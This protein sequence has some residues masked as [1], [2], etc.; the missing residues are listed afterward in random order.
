MNLSGGLIGRAVVLVLAI[1]I[2]G[3]GDSDDDSGPTTGTVT[4]KFGVPSLIKN[5]ASDPLDGGVYVALYRPDDVGDFGPNEGAEP[6]VS[7]QLANL[8]L[9]GVIADTDGNFV[10][11]ETWT[12]GPLEPG[13]YKGLGFFDIDGNAAETPAEGE[14]V[15][16]DTGDPVTLPG[17][18]ESFEI[19]AGEQTQATVLFGFLNP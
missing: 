19:V 15:G 7:I 12:S 10:G 9:V 5:N 4:L 13:E 6:V 2:G 3:C 16:P 11:E 14:D 8:N 17:L 18:V 1:A